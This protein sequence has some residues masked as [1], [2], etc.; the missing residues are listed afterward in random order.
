MPKLQFPAISLQISIIAVP[1]AS[2][3]CCFRGIAHNLKNL[4]RKCLMYVAS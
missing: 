3:F 4:G 2:K 1:Y